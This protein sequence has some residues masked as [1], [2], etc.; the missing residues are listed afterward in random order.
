MLQSARKP[1]CMN[2]NTKKVR[3]KQRRF[4]YDP[5][6]LGD[7]N[8]KKVRLKLFD[9]PNGFVDVLWFQYQKGAIKTPRRRAASPTATAFQYQKGAIKTT[10]T[11]VKS[12]APF[13]N[14]NTKKVRLKR[15]FVSGTSGWEGEDFNTKKVRL[16]LAAP[17]PEQ[18]YPHNFNTKKVR[19]KPVSDR[20][21]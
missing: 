6:L 11:F 2:F 9:P 15:C 13:P 7:F 20:G 21:G 17:T 8:T 10:T 18:P 1:H 5:A 16:K 3:L 12:S 4:S 19:L 14:F